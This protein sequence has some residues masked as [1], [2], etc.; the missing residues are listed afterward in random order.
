MAFDYTKKANYHYIDLSDIDESLLNHPLYPNRTGNEK[1]ALYFA[2]KAFLYEAFFSR[3][4]IFAGLTINGE[5]LGNE[6]P[7][8][9]NKLES[10][11]TPYLSGIMVNQSFPDTSAVYGS[12][13]ASSQQLATIS[14]STSKHL[15]TARP[16]LTRDLEAN[17]NVVNTYCAP[18]CFAVYRNDDILENAE[19]ETVILSGDTDK[20]TPLKGA[21][22]RY[23]YYDNW[24]EYYN[25]EMYTQIKGKI[26]NLSVAEP[27]KS[28]ITY[29]IYALVCFTGYNS[30]YKE[31][32][33]LYSFVE[34]C[35][36]GPTFSQAV[37][38]RG[39]TLFPRGTADD[40]MI[41]QWFSAPCY[42]CYVIA[43]SNIDITL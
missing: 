15:F 37:I 19:Y 20:L 21:P 2:D 11:S 14:Y 1:N 26:F 9:T 43:K 31:N 32:K 13:A 34:L 23:S 4:N 7:K 28:A 35:E 27:A 24:N 30:L 29:K 3:E 17:Y 39:K 6:L 33:T 12:S 22:I 41:Y 10:I 8:L 42:A 5:S 36:D 16:I 25:G 18:Y 40:G 38:N